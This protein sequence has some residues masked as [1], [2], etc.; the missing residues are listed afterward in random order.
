[1]ETIK[2]TGEIHDRII[3]NIGN[4]DFYTIQKK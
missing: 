2:V 1:M 3:K 4:T